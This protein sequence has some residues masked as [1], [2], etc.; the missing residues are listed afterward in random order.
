MTL[1]F[2]PFLISPSL[3]TL[4]NHGNIT[5]PC[6]NSWL[7]GN[8]LDISP[9]AHTLAWLPRYMD[10]I[11]LSRPPLVHNSLAH[12]FTYF[13][14]LYHN[15]FHDFP[16]YEYHHRLLVFSITFSLSCLPVVWRCDLHPPPLHL[17]I[18]SVWFCLAV[19]AFM[20][21]YTL[22]CLLSGLVLL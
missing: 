16:F 4:N 12:A 6:L 3:S 8:H 9:L 5:H 11:A 19:Q 18:L 22:L 14:R 17:H 21:V 13:C 10:C 15:K 2:L 7:M 1:R 20:Y